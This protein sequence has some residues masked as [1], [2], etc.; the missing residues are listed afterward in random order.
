MWGADSALLAMPKALK[1]LVV[2]SIDIVVCIV[3]VALAFYLRLGFWPQPS[4]ALLIAVAVSL[5]STIPIFVA[6]GLY[7]AIFRHVGWAS[8]VAVFRAVVLA[9]IPIIAVLTMVGIAGV[10]RTVGIIQP[11][12]LL[13]MVVAVRASAHAWLGGRYRQS[14][15]ARGSRNVL[16]YGAGSAG[17][18]LAF[19]LGSDTGMR[20]VGYLDDSKGLIGRTMDGLPVFHPAALPTLVERHAVSDILLAMPSISRRRRQEILSALRDLPVHVQ[21]LPGVADLARGRVQV[22][23]LR[24]LEI[25]D[26]LGRKAVTPDPS[27]LARN[28]TGKVVLVSGAGGSIGSELSRQ[29]IDLE[30][31]RLILVDQSE[32]ALYSIHSELERRVPDRAA[33]VLPLLASIQDE[34]R[35]AAIVETWKPHTI[36]H[37]AAYKH[38][39]LVEQN[40]VEGVRNNVHGTWVMARAARRFG[41]ANFVLISTDKAVRPTNVMGAS[42][43]I[44]E[45]VLQA[46]AA[47]PG[48][49]CFSMVRFGNVL[50]SSGSV[51]PLF[52]RQ[53]AQGGPVTVTDAEIT[54]YFMTIPEA[55]E[56]VIQAGAMAEG[57]EVFVLD[58]GEPV[59]IVDLA[60][61]MIK[62]SGLTVREADTPDGDIDIEITGLRPGEKLY[63]E[64]LIGDNPETTRHSRILK[65]NETFTLMPVLQAQIGELDKALRGG[66]P[67]QLREMLFAI[68]PGYAPI[69][70]HVDLVALEQLAS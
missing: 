26:L 21:T 59:K 15:A 37:A 17:K 62:L 7:R 16:I 20:P 19:A 3:S 54:R 56:L 29:I 69:S 35:V 51:V 48:S 60:R 70:A 33:C 24:E 44:A 34:S 6:L 32:F 23:D 45:M 31:A 64:L 43:R 58:M 14:F 25:E 42:K 8:M 18:Q 47:E 10:P 28:I 49:T 30:P 5:A 50:G 46:M 12:L 9:S 22:T 4:R 55:A 67:A 53:I 66:D 68:V 39:P 40:P 63:E 27:L 65:A 36:Y 2:M 52:R 11:L 41:V 57:G 13:I 61:A 38:V 1:R